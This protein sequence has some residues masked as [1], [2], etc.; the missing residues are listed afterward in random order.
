MS[1]H[2]STEPLFDTHDLAAIG[3]ARALLEDV[4][5]RHPFA[6]SLQAL[7]FIAEAGRDLESLTHYIEW[8]MS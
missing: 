8:R 6:L 7:Y 1:K 4:A 5:S 3:E 2:T